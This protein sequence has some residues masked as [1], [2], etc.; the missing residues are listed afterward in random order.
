MNRILRSAAIVFSVFIL[1]AWIAWG[2]LILGHG[3]TD[4]PVLGYPLAAIWCALFLSGARSR[5]RNRRWLAIASTASLVVAGFWMLAS[6]S[7]DRDWVPDQAKLP[8]V[9]IDGDTVEIENVR[10]ARYRSTTDFDLVWESRTYDL[11]EVQSV[12]FVVE[13]FDGEW[14]GSAHTFLSWRFSDGRY[15]AISAEIRREQGEKFSPWSGLVRR[16]ELMLVIGDEQDLIALRLNHRRN[17]VHIYRSNATPE[18]SRRLLVALLERAIAISAR[19]EFYNTAT[20]NCTTCIIEP[21]AKLMGRDIPFGY[22]T[23]LPGYSDEIALENGWIDHS[24]DL[25]SARERYLAEPLDTLD[26]SREWSRRVRL[27]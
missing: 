17:P 22:R 2:A 12:D 7:H 9:S 16:F 27:R 19:P 20:N 11:R 8:V 4:R 6:P 14:R 5:G 15:L 1:V 3:M 18:Q 26:D 13:P 25:E 10:N 21:V 23:L 24:G